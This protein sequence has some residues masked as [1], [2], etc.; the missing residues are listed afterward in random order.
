MHACINKVVV[1]KHLYVC[2]NVE[3]HTWYRIQLRTA[4]GPV[5]ARQSTWRE[6][7]RSSAI[8]Q[9]ANI[10][11]HLHCMAYIRRLSRHRHCFTVD[12]MAAGQLGD[13]LY[14]CLDSSTGTA[15]NGSPTVPHDEHVHLRD[16]VWCVPTMDENGTDIY[17]TIRSTEQIWTLIWIVTRISVIF[18]GYGY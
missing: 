17:S 2:T 10:R 13:C 16:A 8:W 5:R 1:A 12:V 18:F 14:L 15:S 6:R 7:C 4:A 11:H 9:P 3:Y